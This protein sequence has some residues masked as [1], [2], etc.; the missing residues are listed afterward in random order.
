MNGG[1]P[2]RI[3]GDRGWCCGGRGDTHQDVSAFFSEA[4]QAPGNAPDARRGAGGAERN[5]NG[6]NP[7]RIEGDR[8]WCCGGGGRRRTVSVL[9]LYVYVSTCPYNPVC[10]QFLF[11]PCTIIFL[12]T[13]ACS[14]INCCKSLVFWRAQNCIRRD[15]SLCGL[16]MSLDLAPLQGLGKPPCACLWTSG[17][18]PSSGFEVVAW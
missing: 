11:S 1:N 16:L 12:F 9:S 15:A 14:L 5:L 3:E 2:C 10:W 8:G 6:G 17:S 13:E 7:C 4:S 18:A